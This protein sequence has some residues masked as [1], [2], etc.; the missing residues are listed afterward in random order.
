[1]FQLMGCNGKPISGTDE[2]YS[3][4]I[5]DVVGNRIFKGEICVKDGKIVSVREKDN[6]ENCYIAPGLVD[7]HLHIESSMLTPVEFAREA[8]KH[9]T[10]TTVSDPHEIANVLGMEG[11]QFMIENGEKTP[12][13]FCF[14]APSCVPATTFETSGAVLDIAE[15]AQLLAMPQ[16]GYLSEMMNYPGVIYNDPV[17]LQKIAT[18]KQSGKSVDGHAPGLTGSDLQKYIAAG[19]ST[20][21]ESFMLEEAREKLEMGMKI[22]IRESS[23][24]KNFN[25][26][27]PLIAAYPNDI[28]F[29]CDDLH[30]DDLVKGHINL[31]VKR[32]LSYGYDLLPVLRACTFNPVKHY[33]LSAGLLQEG[34][35]ADFIIFDNPTQFNIQKVFINGNLVAENGVSHLEPVPETALNN[36][37]ANKIT[38]ADIELQPLTNYIKVIDIVPDEIV[39]RQ[40]IHPVYVVNGKVESN[41]KNDI[42]KIVMLNRYQ[43]AKP[44]VAFIR[45]SGLKSGAIASSVVHDSHNI[46]CIGTNDAD[47]VLAINAL[48]D[49]KGGISAS[50]NGAVS[51]MPLPYGGLMDNRDASTLASAYQ[52][53][54]AKAKEMGSTLR[55]PYMTL[56]FMGLLVIPEL[57]LSDKGLFDGVKFELTNL[58]VES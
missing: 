8:V 26:L 1:M 42:L 9:G 52:Q 38:A 22:L 46:I 2:T 28:M 40:S 7:A 10:V 49:T 12:F 55:S 33:N 58:F 24:A 36:F 48:I 16:I 41:V 39:T 4:Y 19:I 23:A 3:G 32:A 43:T 35:P 18:A 45:N 57:K 47:I 25:T 21:H 31:L 30:P 15:V 14:G 6:V 37:N 27:H 11:V 20:D 44:A 51:V 56:S 13:K 5:V 53:L 54:D 17:V 34:D 50:L 29:C